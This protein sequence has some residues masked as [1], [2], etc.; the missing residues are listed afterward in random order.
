MLEL[1]TERTES[2]STKLLQES[3]FFSDLLQCWIPFELAFFILDHQLWFRFSCEPR[4]DHFSDEFVRNET[5]HHG[6]WNGKQAEDYGVS[7]LCTIEAV[8]AESFATNE[9]YHDLPRNDDELNADEQVIPLNPLKNVHL[10]VEPSVV[11][12]I[13]NCHPNKR[14]EYQGWQL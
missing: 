2:P 8:C 11:I 12:L 14:I 3:Q 6:Y 13:E 10:V 7:P 5:E 9:Y 1:V 4:W